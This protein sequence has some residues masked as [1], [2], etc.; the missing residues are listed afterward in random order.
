MGPELL[1]QLVDRH[2][3]ALALYARQWCRAP[4]DVV[5]EAFLKLFK[6]QVPPAKVIPWLYRVVR[7]AAISA[8][9]RESCRRR[10]ETAAA[11][12]R[13]GNPPHTSWFVDDPAAALDGE[14]ATAALQVLPADEREVITLHLWAG[15]T[16]E[17]I[18]DVAGCSASTAHRW[19]AAGIEL[20]RERLNVHV[21][22]ST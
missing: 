14:A 17:Q 15:L 20:L 3:A 7:N 19:Y 11:L 4:E 18:A 5:Q 10:H 6:Q 1:G 13:I 8:M 22:T 21:R 12:G 16:F 2:A 9:R